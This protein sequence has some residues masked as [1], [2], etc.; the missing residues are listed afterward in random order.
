MA[1]SRQSPRGSNLLLVNPPIYDFT[2][3]D[4]WLRPYGLLRVGGQL[5]SCRLTVFDHLIF[6]GPRRVRPRTVRETACRQTAG[7]GQR[8]QTLL[9]IWPLARRFPAA[10]VGAKLRCSAYPDGNDLL[11]SGST[12]GYR[13]RSGIAAARENHPGRRLRHSL[14]TSCRITRSRPGDFGFGF[15]AARSASLGRTSVLGRRRCRGRRAQDH[16]RMPLPMHLLFGPRGV[17]EFQCAAA[18][19]IH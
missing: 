9:S 5:R 17:S 1:N 7:P 6:Q 19:G 2:A 14:F 15:E 3:F 18:G 8:S 10:V 11:V 13:G 12:G 4:F 16:G